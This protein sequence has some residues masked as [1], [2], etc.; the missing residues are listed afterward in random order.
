MLAGEAVAEFVQHLD[1]RHRDPEVEPVLRAEKLV[2]CWQTT[3]KY[4]EV[5]PDQGQG[6]QTEHQ[7]AQNRRPS[8][9]PA[10]V[11]VEPVEESLGINAAEA[12]GEDVGELP[13]ELAPLLLVAALDELLSLAAR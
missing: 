8:E 4:R 13:H 3:L 2:K 10:G 12:E 9:K 6:A 1:R 5:H 7:H 11:S